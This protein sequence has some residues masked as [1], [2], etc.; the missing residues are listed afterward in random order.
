[1]MGRHRYDVVIVGSGPNG[2]TAGAALASEGKSCLLIES[3]DTIGGGC[4]TQE[5]TLPGFRHDVCSAVHPMGYMSPAFRQLKLEE[6]GI[7]WIHPPHSVA[8]PLDRQPAVMLSPDKALTA[9]RL[10]DADRT[11]FYESVQ[12][13]METFARVGP[14]LLDP[15]CPRKDLLDLVRFGLRGIQPAKAFA[16]R[17]F[18]GPRAKALFAGCAAHSILPLTA[19]GTAAFGLIFLLSG[20][21]FAWPIAKRGS[22]TIVDAL[23]KTFVSH[24]GKLQ[25]STRIQSF[26]DL[27][28]AKRYVFDL[29][30]KQLSSICGDYL[31]ARYRHRLAR[32][33]YGPAVFKIDYA[34]SE[35]IP[36]SDPLCH[37]AS[38]VHL[39]GTLEEI[40]ASENAAWQGQACSNPFVLVCQQ[41][42]FDA[43]R[44]P[45]GSHTGYAYCHVPFNS[46]VT[47]IVELEKQ[48]ERFAPG[49]KD[50]VVA[51]HTRN[52]KEFE[53]Y[54]SSY[55]GGAITGGANTLSQLLTR[56][57][58]RFVPYA[59][60]N[61]RI[62]LCSQSTPPGGGAHGMCG[63]AAARFVSRSMD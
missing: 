58:A 8:H 44:A 61:P 55:C 36:W 28:E 22:Q 39:G 52:A 23:A 31:P 59:T 53:A 34:L 57:V 7:K 3:E 19:W 54:N 5:L 41:S 46:D 43:T 11:T 48:I 40:A 13:L 2:L 1:M 21:Q 9:E 12:P 6:V 18:D 17:L 25:L 27:P 10:D 51:R 45:E 4:R 35:P 26:S 30:P 29:S 15:L 62:Y 49:F 37:D 56:P 47:P 60:P 20:G 14:Q 24:G 63:Y 38:T 50:C 33:R 16:S 42:H 32:F